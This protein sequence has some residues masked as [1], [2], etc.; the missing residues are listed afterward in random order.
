M[1]ACRIARL[2]GLCLILAGLWLGGDGLWIHA[3]AVLAQH[4]LEAAW[5]R[6]RASQAPARPWP[7]ADTA[8]VARLDAPALG[9]DLI[10]LD[11]TSGSALA[12][13][14][15]LREVAAPD[16][17]P[18]LLIGGHQDTH[19]AFLETL[20]PGDLL[21]L[22]LRAGGR[23]P[24]RVV[25]TAVVEEDSLRLRGPAPH[26]LLLVTCWPFGALVPGRPE[27]YIVVAEPVGDPVHEGSE[28]NGAGDGI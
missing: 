15:G 3:K 20:R 4:L 24:Y 25:A 27:R 9:V 28:G 11:G 7:W 13:A 16:G 26:S 12:F 18:L 8:P 21:G 23:M 1:K 22:T 5:D 17:T 10:L 6:G 14:P 2:A 19:L